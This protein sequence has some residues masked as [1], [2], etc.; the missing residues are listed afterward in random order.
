MQAGILI[1]IP[2]GGA[3]V[4]PHNSLS[5]N[6]VRILPAIIYPDRATPI[7]VLAADNQQI[8]FVNPTQLD[9]EAFWYI[10][11]LGGGPFV[12]H[13]RGAIATPEEPLGGLS[14]PE[15]SIDGGLVFPVVVYVDQVNGDDGRSGLLPTGTTINGPLRTHSAVYKKYPQHW[16]GPLVRLEIRTAGAGGFVAPTAPL[17]YTEGY[18]RVGSEATQNNYTYRAAPKCPFVPATGPATAALDVVPLVVVDVANVPTAGGGRARLDFTAAAPGWTVNDFGNRNAFLRVTR[19]GV[20]LFDEIPIAENGAD[21]L[22]VDD[23]LTAA[24][25][26]ATD[27]VTIVRSSVIINGPSAND[28]FSTVIVGGG[29]AIAQANSAFAANQGATFDGYEFGLL[30]SRGVQG[31]WFHGCMFPSFT[32]IE[33]GS[34]N[35]TNIKALSVQFFVLCSGDG[36]PLPKG[37]TAL[38]P[39]FPA[40]RI[41]GM[42]KTLNVGGSGISAGAFTA[43]RS[44]A[45]YRAANGIN[46]AGGT[47]FTTVSTFLLGSGHTNVG[48][49]VIQGA[50]ARIGGGL[51]SQIV[52]AA[53][54]LKC[55]TSATFPPVNFGVAA[56]QFQ[57][58]A[59]YNG[60]LH[61]VGGSTPAVPLGGMSRISISG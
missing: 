60:N 43:F 34:V 1:R 48:L 54:N 15:N 21:F 3:L 46:V 59:G 45:A 17:T 58:V 30:W 61:N 55:D 29:S 6:G 42:W 35:F 5:Q 41:C 10:Q 26:V 40:I 13:W 9:A 7:G 2:A 39:T 22:I 33:A 12:M 47:F 57:E 52:G 44:V 19:A 50:Q 27:V 36:D 53:G 16:F 28:F 25:I 49:R 51:A 31:L 8:T 38:D 20:R 56:G 14:F 18:L 24:A 32:R 4:F 23:P 37:P 11:V